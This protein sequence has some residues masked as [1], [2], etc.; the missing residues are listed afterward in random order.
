MRYQGLLAQAAGC[1]GEQVALPAGATLRELAEV[2]WARRPA[3][4]QAGAAQEGGVSMVRWAVN[5]RVAGMSTPLADGDEVLLFAGAA[6][7]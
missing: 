4:A 7:G 3:L 5:N 6:G 2:L 1:A